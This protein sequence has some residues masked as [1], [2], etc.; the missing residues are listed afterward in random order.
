MKYLHKVR[1]GESLNSISN[2]YEV[3]TR[4]VLNDN[5]ITRE[6]V[7]E[8][9]ILCINKINEKRHIVKPFETLDKISA[10]YSV[11]KEKIRQFNK[12][13]EV[14]VGEIIYIPSVL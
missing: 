8:G 9:L 2:R 1:N 7:R 12:I 13:T 4:E 3:A 6:A 11:S 5:N 14:F 10:K